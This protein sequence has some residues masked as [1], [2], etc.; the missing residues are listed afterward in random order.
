MRSCEPPRPTSKLNVDPFF[1]TP[2]VTFLIQKPYPEEASRR[3]TRDP[4]NM[5]LWHKLCYVEVITRTVLFGDMVSCRLLMASCC[6]HKAYERTLCYFY[7]QVL[8]PNTHEV[9]T[10][11]H[12]LLF[13]LLTH[14]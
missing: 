11:K 1:S 3:C 2:A 13:N 6:N 7:S 5:V 4:H 9:A 12:R 8:G 14:G 10:K